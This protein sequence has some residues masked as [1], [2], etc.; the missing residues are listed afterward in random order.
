MS[1]VTECWFEWGG[2]NCETKGLRLME[3]PT[4]ETAVKSGEMVNVP[5]RSGYVWIP[6]GKAYNDVGIT[7]DCRTLEDA[8]RNAIAAWLLDGHED[9]LRFSDEPTV[10]YRARV[11]AKAQRS[12]LLTAHHFQHYPVTFDCQ[13][14]RYLWPQRSAVTVTTSGGGVANQGTATSA[15]LIRVNCTGDLTLLV[16]SCMIGITDGSVIIDS[17]LGLCFETDGITLANSRVS[18][19]GGQLDNG[20]PG[21]ESGTNYIS[22][23]LETGATMTSVVVTPRDRSL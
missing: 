13:P 10:A 19:S 1:R 20:F 8:D 21:L 16:G 23:E 7:M 14:W 17:E 18:I 12:S 9:W 6:Q 15:P 11:L 2:V 3:L 22:W 4:R 5:G